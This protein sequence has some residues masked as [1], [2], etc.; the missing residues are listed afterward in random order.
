MWIFPVSNKIFT[1]N[2]LGM[3][4]KRGFTLHA[5]VHFPNEPVSQ[6]ICMK[7]PITDDNDST[8]KNDANTLSWHMVNV[9]FQTNALL[10][11]HGPSWTWPIS[12]FDKN[13]PSCY[14]I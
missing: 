5:G 4:K 11:G 7:L 13:L 1:A 14:N 10:D 2:I 8:H 9:S 3:R 12:E 6:Y